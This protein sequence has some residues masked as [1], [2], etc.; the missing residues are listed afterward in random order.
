MST[1]WKGLFSRRWQLKGWCRQPLPG[2]AQQTGQAHP[3]PSH[4]KWKGQPVAFCSYGLLL[5][6][7]PTFYNIKAK[8]NWWKEQILSLEDPQLFWAANLTPPLTISFVISFGTDSSL[9]PHPSS[10]AQLHSQSSL[11]N[12]AQGEQPHLPLRLL[13]LLLPNYLLTAF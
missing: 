9:T 4:L 8:W 1:I 3:A 6:S 10:L 11:P 2:D 13:V 5:F 12:L 7:T